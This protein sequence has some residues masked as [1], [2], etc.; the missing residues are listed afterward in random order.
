L[1]FLGK[2]QV[3]EAAR[4]SAA[5]E[6]LAGA[7]ALKKLASPQLPAVGIAAVARLVLA[8]KLSGAR[9][10]PA[11][12]LRDLEAA[13]K[14]QDALP[15]M[16]PPYWYYP[17]RQSLGAALLRAGRPVDAERVF[18]DELDRLPRNGW[19]L[20]GL[21]ESLRQQGKTSAAASVQREFETAWQR[22]DVRLDLSWF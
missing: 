8:G 14:A 21:A 22:A 3:E 16:E 9:K 6:Q 18:R 7:E 10:D 2:G 20:H 17:V 13:V 5:L 11:S 15:Y 12:M 4:E 19:G 1:A